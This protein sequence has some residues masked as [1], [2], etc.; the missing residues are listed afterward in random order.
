M[1]C[2]AV[3]N[4][5]RNQAEFRS[6]YFTIIDALAGKQMVNAGPVSRDR[7]CEIDIAADLAIAEELFG[8]MAVS[9][10]CSH[11]PA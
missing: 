10:N 4:A 2:D 11:P 1:F 7:W 6:W 3:E 5:L 8:E 9:Q